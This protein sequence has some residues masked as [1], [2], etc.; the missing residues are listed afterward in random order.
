MICSQDNY[1]IYSKYYF[2]VH[3]RRCGLQPRGLVP[4][5]RSPPATCPQAVNSARR[6]KP[7]GSW[8]HADVGSRCARLSSLAR[9]R[10][11]VLLK[12]TGRAP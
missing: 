9:A 3:Y 1:R 5:S 11:Q 6:R 8:Q 2:L 7:E 4:T 12:P 10:V